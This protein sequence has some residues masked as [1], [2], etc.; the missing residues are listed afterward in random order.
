MLVIAHRGA[1]AYAPENTL[2]AIREGAARGAD[3]V[4]FDVRRTHDGVLVLLHDRL[5]DRTT[6]SHGAVDELDWETVRQ[7]DAGGWWANGRFAGERIPTLQETLALIAD[8]KLSA[9]EVELKDPARSPGIEQ[10]VL[11]AVAE[12]GLREQVFVASFDHRALN[13]QGS[14]RRGAL[15]HGWE[16][17]VERLEAEVIL[18][19]AAML[20][21]RPGVVDRVHAAQRVVYTY[22]VDDPNEAKRLA[23]LGVDAIITNRPDVVRG[24]VGG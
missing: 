4:E 15:L 3:G 12:A 5:L 2:A 7:A 21:L 20:R 18:P 23:E 8:L 9:V 22:T 1:S 19:P 11:A 13:W 6:D 17:G 24:A 16:Q 14:V 10:E